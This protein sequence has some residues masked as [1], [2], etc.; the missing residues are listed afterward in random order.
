ML[1]IMKDNMSLSKKNARFN[2]KTVG[3]IKDY[4]CFR[5]IRSD[6]KLRKYAKTRNSLYFRKGLHKLDK[7]AD[8]GFI[9]RHIRILRYFLKTVLDKDQLALL[10]LKSKRFIPSEDEKK[11]ATTHKK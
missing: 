6:D 3:V 10:K 9:I 1:Q 7:E 2:H 5:F 11:P 8:I 4:L